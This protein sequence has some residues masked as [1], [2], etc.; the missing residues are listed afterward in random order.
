MSYAGFNLNSTPS[1]FVKPTYTELEATATTKNIQV[2]LGIM[3]DTLAVPLS[4]I[5][6]EATWK[7][8][9]TSSRPTL[10]YVHSLRSS[11]PEIEQNVDNAWQAKYDQLI[12]ELPEEIRE[13]LIENRNLSRAEQFTSLVALENTLIL[14]AKALDVIETAATKELS[15]VAKQR[16]AINEQVTQYIKDN[17]EVLAGDILTAIKKKMNDIG[18]NHS[19]YDAISYYSSLTEEGLNSLKDKEGL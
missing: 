16:K 8:N 4:E 15:E 1:D 11:N 10:Q 17:Y 2:N 5:G 13:T 14:F 3:Q 9:A 12:N 19:N 6:K 18:R 7:Y